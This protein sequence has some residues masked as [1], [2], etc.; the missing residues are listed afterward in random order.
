MVWM[1]ALGSKRNVQPNK[2]TMVS[3]NLQCSNQLLPLSFLLQLLSIS[4]PSRGVAIGASRVITTSTVQSVLV[5]L[6]LGDRKRG[7]VFVRESGRRSVQLT[8]EED[9]GGPAPEVP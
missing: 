3:W 6:L 7:G 8:A 4:L 5:L 2:G 9:A 1:I